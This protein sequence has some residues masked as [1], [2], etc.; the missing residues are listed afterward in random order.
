MCQKIYIFGQLLIIV[1]SV[2]NGRKFSFLNAIKTRF[3]PFFLPN[4]ELS[5][6]IIRK[7]SDPGTSKTFLGFRKIVIK[8]FGAKI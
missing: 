7:I 1:G 4:F 8:N 3:L 2:G 6:P 5:D